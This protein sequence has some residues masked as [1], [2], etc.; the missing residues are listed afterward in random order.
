[1]TAQVY[2]GGPLGYHFRRREFPS[3]RR[4]VRWCRGVLRANREAVAEVFGPRGVVW[5][6]NAAKADSE[7]GAC[8]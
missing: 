7:R 3:L 5:N 8:R 6:S 1:M 2:V 4:A